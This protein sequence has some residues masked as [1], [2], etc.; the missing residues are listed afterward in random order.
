M[1]IQKTNDNR[2]RTLFSGTM[3]DIERVTSWVRG[4]LYAE[5]GT[6][7]G[8]E[9]FKTMPAKTALEMYM[10]EHTKGEAR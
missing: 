2:G 8:E 9:Q 1:P 6:V 3:E 5:F 7:E 10:A 4:V